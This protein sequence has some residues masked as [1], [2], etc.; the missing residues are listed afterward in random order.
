MKTINY[1]KMSFGNWKSLLLALCFLSILFS[2]PTT[3]MADPKSDYEKGSKAYQRDD[4]V[5]AIDYLGSAAKADYKP[6]MVLL[7]YIYDKAEDNKTALAW[8]KKAANGGSMAGALGL[9][10]MIASGNAGKI[11][12]K[13]A[14]KWISLA[15]KNNHPPAMT[16]MGFIYSKG[17]LGL[18]IDNKK[19]LSWFQKAAD[20]SYTPAMF[21]LSSSYRLGRL[22]LRK[23]PKKAA[24][25][26]QAIKNIVKMQKE[27]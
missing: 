9:G 18:P 24:E 15:A 20:K 26:D 5:T 19:A 7:A 4:L 8:Y 17:E 25:I 14:F 1:T 21:E 27:P 2:L 16:A 11:D 10:Q 22:G 23:D 3:G 12:N 6:A 13:K